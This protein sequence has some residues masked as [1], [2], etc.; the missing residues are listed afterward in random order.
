M[1]N[2]QARS[3]PQVPRGG[4]QDVAQIQMRHL[5]AVG[6]TCRARGEQNHAGITFLQRALRGPPRRIHIRQNVLQHDLSLSVCEG[7]LIGAVF[8]RQNDLGLGD[9]R[10]MGQCA[11]GCDADM[12]RHVVSTQ[13]HAGKNRHDHRD[14]AFQIYPDPVPVTYAQIGQTLRN[15]RS[16]VIQL[17]IADRLPGVLHRDSVRLTLRKM[18]KPRQNGRETRCDGWTDAKSCKPIDR[19]SAAG[20]VRNAIRSGCSRSSRSD[21]G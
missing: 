9:G 5:Y 4:L 11:I 12:L 19:D 1:P 16:C 15:P 6:H 14:G 13:F 21:S 2:A 8:D 17:S 7:K 3:H 10:D 18:L 20:S